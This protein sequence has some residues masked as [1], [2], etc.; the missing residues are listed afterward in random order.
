MSEP[1]TMTKEQEERCRSL[2]HFWDG[3]QCVHC[4]NIRELDAT[5]SA[6][7]KAEE[8][9]AD[10]RDIKERALGFGVYVEEKLEKLEE[11]AR[12]LLAELAIVQEKIEQYARLDFYLWLTSHDG[13]KSDPCKR[14]QE[15]SIH[16]NA[17]IQRATALLG[18]PPAVQNAD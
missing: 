17:A 9:L 1:L 2:M 13:F 4:C 16:I 12:E 5:R 15:A 7:R 10:E 11:V 3:C 6:L 8:E 14:A 18:D